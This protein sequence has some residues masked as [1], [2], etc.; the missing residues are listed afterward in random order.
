MPKGG[1]Q[2]VLRS[3]VKQ[4]EDIGEVLVADLSVLLQSYRVSFIEGQE[5]RRSW[6]A[7]SMLTRHSQQQESLA[8]KETEPLLLLFHKSRLLTREDQI[9]AVK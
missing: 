6:R 5:D 9:L 4:R 2:F 3:L 8:G 7:G 1:D